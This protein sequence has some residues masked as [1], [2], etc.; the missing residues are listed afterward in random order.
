[1]VRVQRLTGMRPGEVCGMTTRA[2][3]TGGRVWLFRPAR[4]KTA[5]L[6]HERLITLGPK[7]QAIVAKYLRTELDA[8]LFS[9]RGSERQRREAVHA[10]RETPLGYGNRPSKVL[11]A[12]TGLVANVLSGLPGDPQDLR[13][14][15]NGSRI[16]Y[17]AGAPG[18]LQLYSVDADLG[19]GSV[20][21]VTFELCGTRYPS[22]SPDDG[23]VV[24][25]K[26]HCGGGQ[27]YTTIRRVQLSTGAAATLISQSKVNRWYPDWRRF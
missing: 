11:D 23:F 1:M 14:S 15:R 17:R 25:V 16:V 5:N 6:G 7:A 24:Y 18:N 12:S 3:E 22:W 8:P 10:A 27:G 4:H 2:I 26:F 20:Q 21:Q 13:W 9:P 19:P